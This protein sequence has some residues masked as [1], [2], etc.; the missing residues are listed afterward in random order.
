[1]KVSFSFFYLLETLIQTHKYVRKI[2][3]VLT[4]SLNIDQ[5]LA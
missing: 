1:M 3:F 5:I 4:K 2:I